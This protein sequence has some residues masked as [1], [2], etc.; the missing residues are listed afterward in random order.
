MRDL[1]ELRWALFCLILGHGMP[2]CF[3][4]TTGRWERELYGRTVQDLPCVPMKKRGFS[5]KAAK[6]GKVS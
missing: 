5:S 3:E 6:T 1:R 4:P 2:G